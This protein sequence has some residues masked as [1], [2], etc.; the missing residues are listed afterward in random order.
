MSYYYDQ[1]NIIILDVYGLSKLKEYQARGIMLVE[2]LIFYLSKPSDSSF[3]SDLEKG[4]LS[5]FAFN[6]NQTFIFSEFTLKWYFLQ[7]LFNK[8]SSNHLLNIWN[9]F[10]SHWP[11]HPMVWYVFFTLSSSKIS[12]DKKYVSLIIKVYVTLDRSRSMN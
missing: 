10:S 2:E 3:W 1:W 12:G 5:V 8:T 11:D 9:C 4:N 6:N 7:I